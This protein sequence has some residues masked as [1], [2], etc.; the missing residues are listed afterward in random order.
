MTDRTPN[1]AIPPGFRC[2]SCA[3]WGA[4][5]VRKGTD[6]E[7]DNECLDCHASGRQ[8]ATRETETR[9]MSTFEGPRGL[10]GYARIT[11]AQGEKVE[12]QESSAVMSYTIQGQI[13]GPFVWLRVDRGES[14][15][16]AHLS[17][18]DAT[19]LRDALNVFLMPADAEVRSGS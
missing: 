2:P 12:L 6:Y 5:T 1:P 13:E 19:E 9:A 11:T 18:S 8:G 7:N 17:V 3:G 15:S 16:F 14:G 4:T 10:I